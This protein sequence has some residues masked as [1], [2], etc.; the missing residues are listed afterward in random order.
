MAARGQHQRR[1][2]LPGLAQLGD[3]REAV[4][5]RQHH[6]QHHHVERAGAGLSS[7]VQRGFA[8]FHHFHLVAFGF[9]IEAQ[10][11]GQVVLVFDDQNACSSLHRTGGSCRTKVLPRPGPSLS[12][13]ARPPCRL[14]TERT[15]N[16]PRP[17]PFT[18]AASGPGTR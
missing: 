9:Q 3:H 18:R 4:D 7:S 16:S 6:V 10:P 8:R 14:A 5:A 11:I 15:M 2:E 17:V 13:H 12:A 1:N